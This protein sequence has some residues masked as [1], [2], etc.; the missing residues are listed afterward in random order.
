MKGGRAKYSEDRRE[1]VEG[2]RND[3]LFSV[4]TVERNSAPCCICCLN[5]MG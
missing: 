1:V 4:L 5:K 3:H 2:R